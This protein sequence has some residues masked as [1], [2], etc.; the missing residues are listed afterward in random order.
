MKKEELKLVN[1]GS[2]D[3]EAG[4]EKLILGLLWYV[5]IPLFLNP[6]DDM[7]LTIRTIIYHYQI[8]PAL[9]NAPA[10]HGKKGGARD[11]MLEVRCKILR[12]ST[13]AIA[14]SLV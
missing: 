2:S 6:C 5:M 14:K 13:C 12:K 1:I 8:A 3:I 7:S 4:N 9:K 10:A 11:M